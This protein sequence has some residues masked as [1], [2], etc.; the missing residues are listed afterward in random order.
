MKRLFCAA[1]VIAAALSPA[2]AAPP[3]DALL[4]RLGAARSIRLVVEQS[5]TYMERSVYVKKEIAGYRLPFA[6]VARTLLEEAG[7]RVVE[8]GDADA[9]TDATTDATLVITVRG[10]AISRLY[11]DQF[12]GYLFTGAEIIGDIVFSAP[13]APP[14]RTEFRSQHGP[15]FH[16]Q[17]NLG[18]DRPEGAPFAE[19]FD[20]PTSFVARFSEAVGRIWGVGPRMAERLE[21][22]NIHTIGDL[23]AA[24][25]EVL[26]NRL[27]DRAAHLQALARGED[28]RAVTPVHEAKSISRETTFATF[29]SDKEYI[30]TKLLAL[31]ED[32]AMRLRA[33]GRMTRTVSIRVRDE[34]FHTVTRARTLR[35]A[36][37]LGEDIYAAAVRLFREHVDLG[38]RKVRLLGVSAENLTGPEGRQLDL[39]TTERTEKGRDVA[40]VMDEINRKYG[41]GTVQKARLVQDGQLSD[42]AGWEGVREQR[43][44]R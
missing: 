18:F 4:E 36:T 38:G 37:D 10:R 13:G 33:A 16:V 15:P 28:E 32:V 19:A 27:G 42:R 12:E 3:D 34:T 14:W 39:F 8:A 17:I 11:I 22:M 20:G 21:T 7:L 30:E 2:A 5:Y 26:V 23:A 25:S 31:A 44:D 43:R 41:S 6:R 29:L 24:T 35:A 1:L 40:G 9:A